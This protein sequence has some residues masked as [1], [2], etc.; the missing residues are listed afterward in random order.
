MTPIVGAVSRS[1][2]HTFSKRNELMIRLIAGRGVEG[3]VH[4]GSRVKHRYDI[5]KKPASSNLRQV[6]LIHEELFAELWA[7]GFIVQ[8]GDFGENIATKGLDLL[9]LPRE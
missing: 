3:D 8:A 9:S 2:G 5:W 4:F 7:D 6:H 1:A